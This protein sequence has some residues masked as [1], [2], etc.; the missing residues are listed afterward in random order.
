MFTLT[1]DSPV[2]DNGVTSAP[3]LSLLCSGG[4]RFEG[5]QLQTGVVLAVSDDPTSHLYKVR[6]R[7]DNK[8]SD[9]FW[10]RYEDGKTLGLLDKGPLGNKR[11]VMKLLKANDLRIELPAFSGYS[12]VADFSP[13][14]LKRDMLAK[15][16]GLK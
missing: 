8:I 7:I 3:T 6:V 1:S 2:T 9:M 13:A 15:S 5:A 11:Y 16:C 14:G 10:N 4:G 12:A